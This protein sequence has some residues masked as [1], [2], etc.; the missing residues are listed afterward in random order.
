M[1]LLEKWPVTYHMSKK[2]SSFDHIGNVGKFNFQNRHLNGNY[3]VL[4]IIV[5][6]ISFLAEPTQLDGSLHRRK[7]QVMWKVF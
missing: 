6:A 3:K 1:L 2:K 4:T 5:Y 7:K